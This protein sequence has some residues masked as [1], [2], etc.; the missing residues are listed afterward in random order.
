MKESNTPEDQLARI[1][2]GDEQAFTRL[3]HQHRNKIYSVALRLTESTFMAEEVVQE[4]F[5]KIWLKRA[6]LLDIKDFDDY[7]FIVA[8]NHVFSALKRTARQQNM[9]EAW[10]I[11]SPAF[12]NSADCEL[13]TK[14]YEAVIQQAIDLLPAQQK[15]VYLLSKEQELKRE[16]IARL[17]QISTETVKTHLSRA[18]RHIRAYS[19]A[20]LEIQLFWLLLFLLLKG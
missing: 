11:D 18:M 3:F 14:E 9:E 20:K 1:A 5:L 12:E 7:L 13:L 8:R 10:M 17:L 4:V 2:N 16:E 6:S 15:Q 19:I